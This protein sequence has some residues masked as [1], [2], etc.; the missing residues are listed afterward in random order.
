MSHALAFI[1]KLPSCPADELYLGPATVTGRKGLRPTI[2]VGDGEPVEAEMALAFPYNFAIGDVLLV[3]GR[4]GGFYVIGVL[5]S[6]G[7]EVSLRFQGD[8]SLHAVG[9]RLSL[10]GDEQIALR[11]PQLAVKVDKMRLLAGS[12][13]Q[14]VSNFYQTVRETLK[15]HAGDKHELVQGRSHLQAEQASIATRGIITIN[16]KEVHLG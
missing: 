1:D 10:Q 11:T 12:V 7:G 9:G 3:I 15:V 13:V 2:R 8:V 16:G 14:K 4:E 6:K 5:Q